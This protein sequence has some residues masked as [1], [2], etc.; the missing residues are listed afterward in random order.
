MTAT[1][2]V[3][4]LKNLL[5]REVELLDDF[6]REEQKLQNAIVEREWE[7][8]EEIVAQ[9]SEASDR[10]L[11]V[12]KERHECYTRTRQELGCAEGERFYDFVARLD[13]GDRMEVSE[14]YR[15][16]KVSV[17]RV[18]ALTGGIG[19][20]VTSATTAIRDVLDELYPRRKGRIYSRGGEHAAPDDR[21]MV[22]DHHL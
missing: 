6:A 10:V 13:L 5:N 2:G 14:L 1:T 3:E 18:Q 8:L 11:E 20:Y 21:A 19:S 22:V 16:L 17:M 15:R 7:R 9:M 12:E 4:N